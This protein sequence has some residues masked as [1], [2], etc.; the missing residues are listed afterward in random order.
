MSRIALVTGAPGW[1]GSR[2]V[3]A[4]LGRVDDAAVGDRWDLV[5]ALVLPGQDPGRLAG[6][7]PRLELVQGDLRRPD[8]LRP[9]VDGVEGAVVFH[10]AGLIHPKRIQELYEL[11]HLGTEHLLA[12]AASARVQRL[13]YVSSNSVAGMNPHRDHRF[14]EATV[15]RPYMHYG[16][17]KLLAEAAVRA[18]AFAGSLETVVVRPPWY[19]GPFQPARQTTFFTMIRTGKAPIIGGGHNLRSMAYVDNLCQGLLLCAD[20]PAARNRTYWIADRRPYPMHEIVDT[21]ERLMR[22]EFGI[23]CSGGRLRLPAIATEVAYWADRGLQTAG[24]YHQKVHVLSEMDKDIACSIARA[25]AELGYAPAVELQEGMRRS[26]RW[27]RDSGT[28]F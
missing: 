6:L 15:D 22:D 28:A 18:A 27:L 24:L 5:R 19:Y 4:L 17:S 26:L 3:E 1:L 7:D 9:F 8:S 23:R 12:A 13:V 25:E 20:H 21:V 16:R 2:L 10:C 11:N 14:D